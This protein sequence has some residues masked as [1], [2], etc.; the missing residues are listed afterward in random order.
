M[1]QLLFKNFSNQMLFWLGSVFP[2]LPHFYVSEI[3][4]L[5]YVVSLG[6]FIMCLFVPKDPEILFESI[7]M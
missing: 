1:V 2:L 3:E 4:S 5:M 7:G 6:M